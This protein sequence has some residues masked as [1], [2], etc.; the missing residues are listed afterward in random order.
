MYEPMTDAIK[1]TSQDITKT[2]TETFIKNNKALD[3][4][5]EKILE[6][7][8]DKGMIAPY[9]ASSLFNLFK[10]ESTSQF[11]LIKDPNSI[12]MNDFFDKWRYTG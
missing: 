7:M 9:L 12:R 1:K 10:P 4:I 6:L 3:Y 5:N 2:I 8:K 11:I